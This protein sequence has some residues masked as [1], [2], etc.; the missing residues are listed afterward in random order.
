MRTRTGS[1]ADSS[2]T[3]TVV[4]PNSR[5]GERREARIAEGRGDRVR[6]NVQDERAARLE[7][8]DAAAQLRVLP[9]GHERR[10][11]L[12]ERRMVR[13]GSRPATPNSARDRVARER[14]ERTPELT[15]VHARGSSMNA[16][17]A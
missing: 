1:C 12:V 5:C 4:R 15:I 17:D 7:R 8:A 3:S 6:A 16:N 9:Q 13:A 14:E 11:R 10:A 2:D